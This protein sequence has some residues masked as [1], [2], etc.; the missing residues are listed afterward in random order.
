MKSEVVLKKNHDRVGSMRSWRA[1][2]GAYCGRVYDALNLISGVTI[3][4]YL[5]PCKSLE[6]IN[7]FY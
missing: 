2:F 7:V 6:A 5:S 1:S 3:A 4:V